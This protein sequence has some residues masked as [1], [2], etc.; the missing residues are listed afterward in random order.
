MN[1]RNPTRPSGIRISSDSDAWIRPKRVVTMFTSCLPPCSWCKARFVRSRSGSS[2]SPMRSGRRNPR[3][4]SP[5][6]L[7]ASSPDVSSRGSVPGFSSPG[8]VEDSVSFVGSPVVRSV[9]GSGSR[10]APQPRCLP[11]TRPARFRRSPP[12]TRVGLTDRYIVGHEPFGPVPID[13]NRW[14]HSPRDDCASRSDCDGDDR[15]FRTI[16]PIAPIGRFRWSIRTDRQD[17]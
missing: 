1:E 6:R 8:S 15:R 5:D 3:A 17:R 16:G 4:S 10:P 12:R 13:G 11:Q 9:D 14:P 2:E 7:P